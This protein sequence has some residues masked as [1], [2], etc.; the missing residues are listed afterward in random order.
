MSKRISGIVA[1]IVIGMMV[2]VFVDFILISRAV[3]E[4]EPNLTQGWVIC[5]PDS[6]VFIRSRPN[7][8]GQES[9]YLYLGDELT[10]DKR[11][12]GWAHAIGLS[13]EMGEGWIHEGYVDYWEPEIYE[14]PREMITVKSAVNARTCI[15][16]GRRCKLKKGETVTVY[17]SS[18]DWT[19]TDKGFIQSK[20]L[21][22]IREEDAAENVRY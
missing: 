2:E 3:A 18:E 8:S 16:G 12:G 22:E 15:G 4:D 5:Q 19:I 17:A 7:K 9:G 1:A 14:A 20:L 11:Y 10:I 6:F 21:T 13:T